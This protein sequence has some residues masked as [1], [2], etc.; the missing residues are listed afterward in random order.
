MS[1]EAIEKLLKGYKELLEKYLQLLDFLVD[2]ND[3]SE[4]AKRKPKTVKHCKD[5]I[6]EIDQAL[7]ALKPAPTGEGEITKE[8]FVNTAGWFYWIMTEQK[9]HIDRLTAEKKLLKKVFYE[10]IQRVKRIAEGIWDTKT[11][12]SLRHILIEMDKEIAQALK[13]S[14]E[15][16]ER[17]KG[18]TR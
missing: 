17:V 15:Q 11:A 16:V 4:A 18:K 9:A 14:A 6:K 10:Y 8:Q 7:A 13:D 12:V 3:T 2:K 5:I 1:E